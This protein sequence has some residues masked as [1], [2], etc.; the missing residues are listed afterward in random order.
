[1]N[2]SHLGSSSS[3]SDIAIIGMSALF[4]KAAN[5][6]AYWHNILHQVD[7]VTEAPDSWANPYFDP[8]SKENNRIYTRKGGFLGDLAQ[9]NP[10]EFGIM[11]TA[12]DGGEPDQFLAL[13]LARDA[14]KDAGYE[15]KA[16]NRQKT[17][18]ILGRGTYVNRGYTTLLQHGMIVDQTLELLQQLCP[19]LDEK[20]LGSVRQGLKDSLPPFSTEM[21]PGLVPN[22]VTGRIANRLD[23]MGP[24]F[25]IDAACASSL[26]AVELA[27]KELLS[28]RCDM[29]LAG[30]IHAST[31]PQ[32]YMIFCQL[33]GLSH[34]DIRPFDAAANGTLLGEGLGILVL[35]R[36][37]DA[38]R[39][40]DRIYAVLK[41]IGSA[42][43]GKAL[44]LLAPRLEG[45]VLA[46]QRAYQASGVEPS[47]IGLIEAHG[48]SIP[49][50]DRTE[51]QAL[52]QLFG[53]RNGQIPAIALGSVKSSIG[54]CI[55]AAGVAGIIKTALS[56]YHKV[57]PPTLCEQVNPALG[58]EQTPFYIN[59]SARPWVHGNPHT[60]RRAGVNAF[61]FGGINA[62]AVLEEYR[63]TTQPSKPLTSQP[64]SELLIFSGGELSELLKLLKTT[65]THLQTSP[66]ETLAH[67]GLSLSQKPTGQ[68]RLAIIATSPADLATKI[69]L[70]LEKLATQP[71]RF[72]TRNGIYYGKGKPPG[73]VAFLFPGEGAQY[74]NMLADL[75]LSFPQIREWFDFLDQ[76]FWEERPYRPSQVIFPPPT[77]LTTAEELFA[78]RQLFAMDIGSETVFTASMALYELL[79]QCEIPCDAMVGHSTGENTA[80]IA[81]GTARI[82]NRAQLGELM[83][84][85]NQLYQELEASDRI[86]KGAL[87]TV[88]AI[89]PDLMAQTLASTEGRL[90]WAM[91]N[92][93]N[94]FVLFGSETDIE[95]I[96]SQLKAQG[97]ICLRLP[98]DRAYHTPLFASVA[99]AFRA[100]YDALNVGPGKIPLYSCATAEVFPSEPDAIRAL[101]TQQWSNRVRF[102]E[103][104]ETLYNRGFRVFVE[105]G[106]SS[107]LTAFVNDI[108]R[109]RDVLAVASNSRRRPGLEQFQHLLGRLFASGVKVNLENWYGDSAT[110]VS[111]TVSKTSTLSLNMPVMRLPDTLVQSVRDKIQADTPV[112][113]PVNTANGNGSEPEFPSLIPQTA[114]VSAYFDLMQDFLKGQEQVL[115]HFYQEEL[116]SSAEP[117]AYPF[118]GEI[119]AQDEQ[120]LECDR[121]FNL[122]QDPFLGDHTLG[123]QPSQWQPDLFAL[124]V[125]PF[126][127][128][129][130]MIAEAAHYLLGGQYPVVSLHNLRAY[131]WLTLDDGQL[132]L[133]IRAQRQKSTSEGECVFVRI[134]QL[135][136]SG[137]ETGLLVFEGEV[138]LS[139]QG[140]PPPSPR[141]FTLDSPKVPHLADAD[142]YRTGMF[143]GP[144]LQGVKHLR[145]WSEQGIEADLQVL[146]VDEFFSQTAFPQFQI[147]PGLL[148]AAGQLVGYWL[149]EQFG[150]DFNCFPF[151]VKAFYQYTSPLPVGSIVECRGK[152]GFTNSQQIEADFDLL[153]ATGQVIARLEQWQDRYFTMPTAFSQCRLHPQTAYLSEAWMQAETGLTL[154]RIPAF[155]RHFLDDAW[156]IWQRVLVHLMLTPTERQIWYNFP[157]GNRRKDWL[158]GRIAAKDAIRQ[159]VYQDWAIALAP[160]DIEICT[161]DLGKPFA[162]IPLLE[163]VLPDL[164]I[165]HTG[166]EAIAILAANDEQIG[167]DLEPLH[168]ERD[169]NLL[170]G[171]FTESEQNLLQQLPKTQQTTAM[172]A[173][174][175]A[176]E[177]AAKAAG[178]GLMGAPRRWQVYSYAPADGQIAIEFEEWMF[179]VQLWQTATHLFTLCQVSIHP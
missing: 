60:P 28:H 110:N 45:E 35:K 8:N 78:D 84:Y 17:G 41:G 111:E 158:L 30:G 100:F 9:F 31:P 47:S 147:D 126:T 115:S 179:S 87:L 102:R 6:Q 140:L 54:H 160:I 137:P 176:K 167:I 130:E 107:N 143:H 113:Y 20:T 48:T 16:F 152:I 12:V 1:M 43:D 40:R 133:R 11:P 99:T 96:S 55:P 119:L 25:I 135:G 7:A 116:P 79:K 83:R 21:L 94:Q 112:E 51:I 108:L 109:G 49:L 106:P 71:E 125:I 165:A 127:F 142:L 154:R 37:A 14:L 172:L 168:A 22:N 15:Q 101:A 132:H 162:E 114:A 145:Q 150:P 177:A 26:I 27:I 72:Q 76:T 117:L 58:I 153:D 29:V 68:H 131:R 86:P 90:H 141:P 19:H 175:C 24:N 65:L 104:I 98:F 171:A 123:S 170:Q 146:P 3:P 44:G 156:A 120:Y 144:L 53:P 92:C 32:I 46:L 148:D 74:T 69:T 64:N 161:T 178:T 122:H 59:T 52:S 50:G 57:L 81:S 134:F 63:D 139:S 173:F 118:L 93:S 10:L 88:G 33:G 80:L 166:G 89:S 34:S 62:H 121:D 174:W 105:V 82:E 155:D 91:D 13:K 2:V 73:K 124:P 163:A 128:S 138:R 61:G 149:T 39:D 157:A 159:R 38:Q 23:L 136:T 97:G 36:L 67:L 129:M 5:L 66:T 70:A 56:L 42:S 169:Y 103:T 85:L 95:A 75:C 151:Q 18:I 77:S 164:S 4:A